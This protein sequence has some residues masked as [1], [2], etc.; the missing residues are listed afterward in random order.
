M[1]DIGNLVYIADLL[2][3]G[4]YLLEK[5]LVSEY[6]ALTADGH[7]KAGF[8]CYETCQGATVYSNYEHE[9]TSEDLLYPIDG[10]GWCRPNYDESPWAMLTHRPAPVYCGTV[11]YAHTHMGSREV[12]E[13]AYFAE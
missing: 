8:I 5:H 9:F 12:N 10:K 7:L 6:T 1:I 4:V 2:L 11:V 13:T 3:G